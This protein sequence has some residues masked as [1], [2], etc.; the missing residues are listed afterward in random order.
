MK[1]SELINK[2]AYEQVHAQSRGDDPEVVVS[3]TNGE[4]SLWTAA[5]LVLGPAKSGRA[6]TTEVVVVGSLCARRG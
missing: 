4:S 2:L 1:L 6:D 5:T 3:L